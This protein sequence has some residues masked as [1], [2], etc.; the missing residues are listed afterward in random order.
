MPKEQTWN[1]GQL[2]K[3]WD[4]YM[5]ISGVR[6]LRG[7]KWVYDFSGAPLHHIKGTRAEV[8]KLS[9]VLTFPQYLEM[10]NKKGK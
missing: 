2:K 9:Q 7:G 5:D 1:L 3:L 4:R 6:I 10:A 8:I